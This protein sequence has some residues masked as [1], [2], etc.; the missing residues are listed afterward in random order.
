MLDAILFNELIDLNVSDN[1][2]MNNLDVHQT[3]AWLRSKLLY[4]NNSTYILS[5]TSSN[6]TDI[7]NEK[8]LLNK[9]TDDPVYGQDIKLLKHLIDSEDPIITKRWKEIGYITRSDPPEFNKNLKSMRSIKSIKRDIKSNPHI[10]P[11]S[12]EKNDNINLGQSNWV[13]NEASKT[14]TAQKKFT[15][16]KKKIVQDSSSIKGIQST[17]IKKR[18]LKS[19]VKTQEESKIAIDSLSNKNR[20]K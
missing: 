4:E 11:R 9:Y 14:I 13:Q 17:E 10:L 12:N 8:T 5:F 7:L 16:S 18:S 15:F 20:T 1:R 3:E 2:K 19:S 6:Q